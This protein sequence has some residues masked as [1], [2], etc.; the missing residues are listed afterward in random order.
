MNKDLIL[1]EHL[2]IERTK[3]ANETTLLSYIRTG[4][5]FIVAGSTLGHLIETEFWRIAGIPVM[6]AGLI[7]IVSG[8][9]RYY[10]V[11]KVIRLSRENIGAV[12][13]HYIESIKQGSP[14]KLPDTDSTV[15][16]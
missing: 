2:A 8:F 4:L 12:T 5:Y 10:R 3:L 9:L 11:T 7:I 1:R 13:N 6:I 15:N 16:Q 14:A